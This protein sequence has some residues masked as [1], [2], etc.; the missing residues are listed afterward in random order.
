MIS[1]RWIEEALVDVDR[2]SRDRSI[3]R[4]SVP[5]VFTPDG[6]FVLFGFDDGDV[7]VRSTDPTGTERTEALHRA[8]ITRIEIAPNSA[9]VFTE[10]AEGEQRLWPL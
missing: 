7:I 3:P 4:A 1:F 10:D 8:P 6:K 2:K 5:G 9:W